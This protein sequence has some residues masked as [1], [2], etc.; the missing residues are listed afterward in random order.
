LNLEPLLDGLEVMSSNMDLE[1]RKKA[2]TR[3]QER[4]T[5]WAALGNSDAIS[6]MSSLFVTRYFL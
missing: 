4:T 2:R 3:K 6:L 5:A 1:S